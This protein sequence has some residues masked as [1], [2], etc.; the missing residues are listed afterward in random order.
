M[1]RRDGGAG[2]ARVETVC[3]RIEHWRATREKRSPMPAQLWE[4]AVSVA[5]VHGV[6]ATSR[7]LRINYESL[8]S[9]V[10]GVAEDGRAGAACSAGFVELAAGQLSG[11]GERAG[12][13][14][15]LAGADGATVVIRLAAGE[16]LD[17]V[18]LTDA[19]W[20]RGV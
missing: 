1:G 12:T 19:F 2:G 10:S 6:W 16:A 7:V 11:A 3:R 20:R 9:R 5:R 4:A 17:V 8:K 15:E 14:V 18:A 13:V